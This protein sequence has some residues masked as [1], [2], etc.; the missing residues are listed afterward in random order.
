MIGGRQ[1]YISV[2]RWISRHTILALDLNSAVTVEPNIRSISSTIPAME[3]WY[4]VRNG[5]TFGAGPD[6]RTWTAHSSR[7]FLFSQSVWLNVGEVSSAFQQGERFSF[8]SL[9][10]TGIMN[11]LVKGGSRAAVS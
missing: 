6:Y 2:A 3:W 10:Q 9:M 11:R 7:Q 5:K 4:F 1:S 8:D